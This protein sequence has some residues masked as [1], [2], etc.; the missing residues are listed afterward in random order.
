MESASRSV[1]RALAKT[2]PGLPCDLSL[3][4]L[5]LID[6]TQNHRT[7]QALDSGFGPR[8]GVRVRLVLL[9]LLA[10]LALSDCAA[11]EPCH[12]VF[13]ERV[14]GIVAVAGVAG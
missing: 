11:Q 2:R 13:L 14:G 12:Q 3:L 5:G 8:F 9:A 7:A 10:R 6:A 4:L 1:A